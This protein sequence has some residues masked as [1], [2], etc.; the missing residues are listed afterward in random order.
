MKEFIQT[1]GMCGPMSLRIALSRFG[2][3]KSEESLAELCK[4]TKEEGTSHVNLAKAVGELGGSVWVTEGLEADQSLRVMKKLM[5]MGKTII[6]GWFKN[7]EKGGEEH[8]SVVRDVD[9]EFIYLIDP[10]LIDDVK[11]LLTSFIPVW[12]DSDNDV[13]QWHWFIAVDFRRSYGRE[14]I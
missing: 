6:V 7:D 8:Y 11:M 1:N 13:R 4:S 5:S 3:E 9:D 2:I 10:E 12:Y 14:I